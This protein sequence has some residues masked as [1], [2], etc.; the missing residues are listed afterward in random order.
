MR[1]KTSHLCLKWSLLALWQLTRNDAYICRIFIECHEVI[2]PLINIINNYSSLTL[3][4][5][6]EVKAAALRVL[7][8]LCINNEAVK[9]IFNECVSGKSIIEL[10]LND[11]C[12]L[13][14]REAV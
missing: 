13:I 14:V 1:N 4:S 5:E 2:K 12:D 9:H 8:Q 7:T 3:K 6:Q 10:V 11:S